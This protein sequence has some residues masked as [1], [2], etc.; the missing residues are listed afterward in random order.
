MQVPDK[1]AVAYDLC[2]GP[3]KQHEAVE[4][5]G[6]R[7]RGVSVDNS[8]DKEEARGHLHNG[9]KER[10]ADEAWCKGDGQLQDRKQARLGNVEWSYLRP[11][12]QPQAMQ[13]SASIL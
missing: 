13:A 9:S 6:C 11:N 2:D 3:G 4:G 10:G 5:R 1:V 8:P 7:G 12:D